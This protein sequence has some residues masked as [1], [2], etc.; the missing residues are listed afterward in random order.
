VA[1]SLAPPSQAQTEPRDWWRLPG[2]ATRR[3]GRFQGDDGRARAYAG[4]SYDA[5]SIAERYGL[6]TPIVLGESVVAVSA[7][8]GAPG[9][10]QA[11]SAR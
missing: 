2:G 5:G 1:A 8:A 7:G 4:K 6:F 11:Q 10:R 9:R 3:R